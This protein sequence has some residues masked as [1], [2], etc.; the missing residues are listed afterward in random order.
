[1]NRKK[2]LMVGLILAL[3]IGCATLKKVAGKIVGTSFLSLEE[4]IEESM[5]R[6]A[7]YE[8]DIYWQGTKVGKAKF[9]GAA[10]GLAS[11]SSIGDE[12]SNNLRKVIEEVSFKTFPETYNVIGVPSCG[13]T[14]EREEKS[15]FYQGILSKDLN[16][17][18]KF[19]IGSIAR[20]ESAT[21]E[22][23]TTEEARKKGITNMCTKVNKTYFNIIYNYD[24]NQVILQEK[25]K[26]DISKS[27]DSLSKGLN[28]EEKWAELARDWKAWDNKPAIEMLSADSK[29]P[30]KAPTKEPAKK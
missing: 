10:K 15:S 18:S 12:E 29:T 4:T 13:K 1:M 26:G 20:P 25:V 16:G 8:E 3:S 24:K 14:K 7:I 2:I 17:K 23:C 11:V 19:T 27:L 21:C 30:A 6:P 5:V 22:D 28:Y 9:L